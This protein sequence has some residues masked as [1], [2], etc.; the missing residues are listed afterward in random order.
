MAKKKDDK[1]DNMNADLMASIFSDMVDD[2]EKSYNVISSIDD[3]YAL[4]TGLLVMDLIMNGGIRNGWTTSVGYEQTGKTA[5][6]VKIMGSLIKEGIPSYF[7]DSEGALDTANMCSMVGISK[8]EDYFGKRSKDSKSW[9]IAPKIRYTV[10]NNIEKIFGFLC[11]ILTKFPDKVYE[12]SKQSWFYVFEKEQ[13]ELLQQLGLKQDVALSSKTGKLWCKAPNGNFQAVFILDSLAFLV[14]DDSIKDNGQ[15][16]KQMGIIQ[17]AFSKVLKNFKYLLR[18]KHAVF[19]PTNPLRDNSSGNPYAPKEFEPCGNAVKNASDVRNKFSNTSVPDFYEK[20]KSPS[21]TYVSTYGEEKSVEGGSVDTYFYKKV[22]N[23]KNKSGM[24][25]RQ[26]I[27]RLWTKDGKGKP[28]GFDP[29]FDT[30]EYLSMTK[31]VQLKKVG[32]R[33]EINGLSRLIEGCPDAIQYIDFKKLIIGQVYNK[34]EL[35]KE[36][37]TTYNV[38]VKLDVREECFEQ[39]RTSKSFDLL[40]EYLDVNVTNEETAVDDNEDSDTTDTS[41]DDII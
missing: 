13:K 7:I 8:A 33:K 25:L 30:L 29:V 15:E 28:R 21:G 5:V 1:L 17:K 39:V 19:L 16:N 24:P 37:E 34:K 32:G 18:K 14:A 6:A 35:V 38:T 20:G 40:E 31:Q 27:I 41:V 2:C 4:S 11:S 10:Q 23:I 9:E 3:G 12:A 22:K 26:G 36:F